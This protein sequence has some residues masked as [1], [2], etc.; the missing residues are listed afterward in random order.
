MKFN[1]VEILG[2]SFENG[3]VGTDLI[4]R[5]KKN[6]NISGNL[7]SLS[8]T[9][10]VKQILKETNDLIEVENSLNSQDGSISHGLQEIFINDVSF[11]E[12]LIISYSVRG[13]HIQ[14]ASYVAQIEFNE[15]A[16]I[17]KLKLSQNS[18]S[19]LSFSDSSISE[20]D[21]K[22]LKSISESFDFKQNGDNVDINHSIDCSF[23]RRSSIMP[24]RK[25]LW[26]NASLQNQKIAN[27]RNKGKGSIKVQAGETSTQSVSL[28]AG[29]YILEFDYLGQDSSSVGVCSLSCLDKTISLEEKT[30]R[31]KIE[32]S[33]SSNSSVLFSL[34][35]NQ[36]RDTFF[37]NF[38][39]CKKEDTPLE[40]SRAFASFLL[41]SSSEYPI[42]TS[43]ISEKYSAQKLFDNFETVE[44]FDEIDLSYS[45]SKKIKY[46]EIDDSGNYSNKNTLTIEIG[47]EGIITVADKNEIKCLSQRTDAKIKNYTNIVEAASRDRCVNALASY[48]DYYKFGCPTPTRTQTIDEN[49]IY[50][51]E[52]NKTVSFDFKSCT[53]EL[54]ITYTND[55]RNV[56]STS[57]Y[58]KLEDSLSI[59]NSEGYQ[60]LSFNGTAQGK[61]DDSNSRKLNAKQSLLDFDSNKNTIINNA[62]TA[63]SLSGDFIEI[64]RTL[65]IEDVSGR[66]SYGLVYSNKPSYSDMPDSVK[67][68]VKKYDIEVSIDER[69]GVFNEFAVNCNAVAQLMGD[70]FQPKGINVSISVFG[71]KGV[72]VLDLLNA[73]KTILLHKNLMF[74]LGS[75]GT[76]S[77]VQDTYNKLE[78]TV[79]EDFSH[80]QEED[81]IQYNRSVIDLSECPTSTDGDSKHGWVDLGDVPTPTAFENQV[82]NPID[83]QYSFTP[84]PTQAWNY[85]DYGYEFSTPIV[86]PTP[87]PLPTLTDFNFYFK[88]PT[89]TQTA[90]PTIFPTPI[91]TT[92]TPTQTTER[93]EVF[94]PE[95]FNDNIDA[96]VNIQGAVLIKGKQCFDDSGSASIL[97]ETLI[98][99]SYASNNNVKDCIRSGSGDRWYSF[100]F[101]IPGGSNFTP[102]YTDDCEFF[103]VSVPE[104]YEEDISCLI[105]S[106]NDGSCMGT[107]E[108]YTGAMV[109][110]GTFEYSYGSVNS[111]SKVIKSNLNNQSHPYFNNGVVVYN[112]VVFKLCGSERTEFTNVEQRYITQEIIIPAGSSLTLAEQIIS[113]VSNWSSGK[114][115][116]IVAYKNCSLSQEFNRGQRVLN[117]N[118]VYDNCNEFSN[119]ELI[120]SVIVKEVDCSESSLTVNC[121]IDYETPLTPTSTTTSTTTL[122]Q[123]STTTTT[124]TSTT[125]TTPTSTTTTT[126]TS[127]TTTTP[128]PA[129]VD[130]S[131]C[132][133]QYI[134]G[135]GYF[136]NCGETEC[137]CSCSVNLTDGPD[138]GQVLPCINDSFST[139]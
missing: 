58:Y 13:S 100:I 72:G 29:T 57:K 121:V 85:N 138:A 55:T 60:L 2:V 52:E 104:F 84:P 27:L 117:K 41:S 22:Y 129:T 32:F 79:N 83:Y 115:F 109:N 78:F 61:G 89:P 74:G 107:D 7:L 101:D 97:N 63:Y 134:G 10:G 67:N 116:E 48:N 36:S 59:E 1:N 15:S 76:K 120:Y 31:K 103:E 92:P 98:S 23:D 66:I 137:D 8:N 71:N 77:Y 19:D 33:V 112:T 125:T 108:N 40:K 73:S 4:F 126:P 5:K 96:L 12:G 93:V 46:S 114:C 25:N 81:K 88:T 70:L 90:T 111:A 20:E 133:A 68:L 64:G 128:T 105:R 94:I 56:K 127:T 131:L 139:C 54:S 50:D 53:S 35:A 9:S 65:S 124:P 132:G 51:I 122:T 130:C 18:V 136:T 28:D 24:K 14:D 86:Q 110:P 91:N 17:T 99:N 44:S 37:D 82:F 118:Q 135:V 69:V 47:E 11:G 95:N 3:K 87:T 49:N 80:N 38:Y 6:I 34:N 42:I 123:T 21:F 45:I 39:L 113:G 43:S 16:D 26:Q 119:N 75:E 30:G 102:P 106:S 62:K